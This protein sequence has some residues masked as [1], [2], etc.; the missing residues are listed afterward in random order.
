VAQPAAVSGAAPGPS[1]FRKGYAGGEQPVSGSPYPSD[2]TGIRR[3]W[4]LSRT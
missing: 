3:L 2:G 1:A 4:E